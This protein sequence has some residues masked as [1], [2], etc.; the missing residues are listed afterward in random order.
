M[1]TD[2]TAE[3]LAGAQ[4]AAEKALHLSPEHPEGYSGMAAAYIDRKL[5]D[6]ALTVLDAA[7]QRTTIDPEIIYLRAMA[8]FLSGDMPRAHQEIEDAARFDPRNPDILNLRATV[9][10][11]GGDFTAAARERLALLPLV[12]DSIAYLTGSFADIMMLEPS[13]MISN[14][15]RVVAAYRAR[16]ADRPGDYDGHYRYGRLLAA[17]GGLQEG[18]KHLRSLE[19]RLRDEI[20]KSPENAMLRLSLAL[21]LTRLG[22]YSDAVAI[23]EISVK[24]FPD[25]VEAKYVLAQVYAM[26]MY[27]TKTKS[28]DEHKLARAMN[29]L[30]EA[31]A[32]GYR[33]NLLLSADF[34]HLHERAD[35]GA[36]L[37]PERPV[38]AVA[39]AGIGAPSG[40]ESGSN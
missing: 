11:L 19:T 35:M 10:Q 21:T 40:T 3:L 34:Y 13:L 20:A 26:Q 31:V 6:S 27:S 17:S 23:G 15:E 2:G 32:Q 38:T 37:G 7:G 24:K 29:L 12:D 22:E 5:F 39:Q 8:T 9:L 25:V 28:V 36:V 14:R 1:E 4:L 18:L 33:E 30:R 16:L